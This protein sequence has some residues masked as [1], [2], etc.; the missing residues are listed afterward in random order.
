MKSLTGSQVRQMWLTFFAEKGHQIIEGKSLVPFQDPTL[1]WINSG[2]AALKKY[3]DGTEIPQN[4]RLTNAQKS[5]RTNDIEQ[6]GYTARHHT[7]FEMLGNF[8]IG[9]YFRKEAITWAFELLTN[10]KWFGFEI[11]KLYMTYSP[12]D[13]ETPK[14]WQSLGVP[15][16]HLF[17]IEGNFW[18]IG[19]GPCGP[20]TE[21]FYDRG[22]KYDP[23]GLG[24]RLLKEEIS[25]DRYIEI[26][27][28]VFS[29]F[30]AITGV[31]RDRYKELPSKNIDTGAGLERLV[32]IFQGTP[33][34]FETD[35]F[36]PIIQG[37]EKLASISYE[38][39][40]YRPYRVIADHIRTLTFALSDGAIF[41]NEGRGYVLRRILRRAVRY[42][43]K[44]GIQ[45]PFLT[46]LIPIVLS[47]MVKDYPYLQQHQ[48]TVSKMI[49]QEEEKFLATLQHGETLLKQYLDQKQPITGEVAFKLY[50][51]YGFPV[52]LTKEIA[53]EHQLTV[54]MHGFESLMETQRER[55]RQARQTVGSMAKQSADLLSFKLESKFIDDG[56]TIQ[57]KV[58]GIFKDGIQ[59]SSLEDE[60]EI[61]LQQTNFYA[62]SGGQSS[63]L[64][65]MSNTY[66]QLEV[67]DVQKAPHKQ[68]LHKVLVR[69]GV[70]K[71]GD[72]LT[73]E[74]NRQRRQIIRQHHS[75]LHLLQAALK[76]HLGSHILQQGSYVGDQ[77]ARFDFTHPQKISE[78]EL[79]I[80]EQDVNDQIAASSDCVIELMPIDQARKTGATAPFEEKY[81]EIVRIVTLGPRSKE[82][83]GG[84]HVNNTQEIGMFLITSEESIAAG[85]RRLVVVAGAPAYAYYTQKE[86]MMKSLR[87][88]LKAGSSKEIFD[89]L[90]SLMLEKE[91]L[92]ESLS[93]TQ[94]A[95]AEQTYLTLS[96]NLISKPFMHG[97]FYEPTLT[98]TLLMKVMD[99]LKASNPESILILIGK[100]NDSYPVG[101]YVGSTLRTPQR[102]ASIIT[103]TIAQQMQGSGGGKP[104]L[105]FGA[106][107][108]MIDLK[109]VTKVWIL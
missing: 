58:I 87:D 51:T 108:E 91:Q 78:Q 74:I 33:T 16:D 35:L 105:A 23:K 99:R 94:E 14:I 81:G 65:T 102:N 88:Q 38:K 57:A 71:V 106:G 73:L 3:F 56:K 7:F 5:L 59:K 85:T 48:T 13:L 8:S 104:D 67:I 29:Q 45:K 64:G 100:D 61:I 27:N 40:E 76:K 96:K 21:I 93:S 15:A 68:H 98:R 52:E 36:F 4:K 55:A 1:L 11:D 42:G 9:D 77:Y 10:P 34:N 18:E 46:T 6:V 69:F 20:N 90:K 22:T 53:E 72:I 30:N 54:D 32:S 103:K 84:T 49:L 109:T 95:L 79:A 82:F 43:K 101:S 50:D 37:I 26:W 12:L 86:R 39:S 97:V 70:I 17:A 28:I 75:S 107:K 24:V 25:N 44:I 92:K 89:R 60:G 63:D 41:S 80:I 2:V 47:I 66:T 62:E 31:S 19:E 83:C